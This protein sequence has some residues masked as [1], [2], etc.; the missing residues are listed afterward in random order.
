MTQEQALNILKSGQNVFLTGSAGAGKTYVLNQYI[1]YLKERKVNVATT[2]ST[3]IA[4]THMNGMTIHAWSG[5]G[6]R[7][8][9]TEKDL[10]N[11]ETKAYLKKQ[12]QN[13]KVL[14]IDEISMLHKA[15][16]E[17]VNTVLK[18]FKDPF[19]PFGGVQVIF[20]GDFFQLPPVGE[21]HSKH[22]F[23]FM[24]P[25]WV[26]ANLAICYLTQQ[27]R[28][29]DQTL[30][31]ILNEIRDGVITD[32]ST[33]LLMGAQHHAVEDDNLTKLYT[34]NLDV[35]SINLQALNAL[36]TPTKNFKASVK[37][38]EKLLEAFKKSVP[39]GEHMQ[40][41]VGAKVMFVKN[42][43]EVG[44]V[45]GSMGEVVRFD[46]IGIPV[47][48]LLDGREIIASP[49]KWSIEDDTGKA[50]AEYNQIPLRL[51]WAIT[52]HK[53]QGMTLDA[54][55]V[56]LSKTFERGQGYVALSRLKDLKNLKLLGFNQTALEVDGL[57]MKADQRFRELSS[58]AE[59]QFA[60]QQALLTEAKSFIRKV[61]GLTSERDIQ[62]Q[63]EKIQRKK[64][65]K[66]TY[67]ITAELVEQ[68]YSI[69]QIADQRGM[70]E[71]TII[72]HLIQIK[73]LYPKVDISGYAPKKADLT[74]IKKAVDL[75]RQEYGMEEA[76]KLSMIKSMCK[77]KFDFN[78]IKLALIF[79]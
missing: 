42:N 65:K 50:L 14:I 27:Y 26:E 54:A 71:G 31:N 62:K 79:I 70:T 53:S 17:M 38:N 37:G 29:S 46:E 67:Q 9:I 55:E 18:H 51:A 66:N 59:V 74:K 4:A 35:N 25:A 49:E 73:N 16:I 76:V 13:A 32:H 20:S 22:K 45:N 11:L 41:K 57:A 28:Q 69:S 78:Q 72:G 60:D 40:L 8:F 68:N 58:E 47:V 36:S 15:Q 3:G 30:N 1:Q 12:L 39:A 56:D 77:H 10:K 6:V 61:D 19:L 33:R 75:Y 24:A 5:I 52:V 48:K 23:A 64:Q 44:Y 63:K 7:N 2:A 43:P 34:H 21:E